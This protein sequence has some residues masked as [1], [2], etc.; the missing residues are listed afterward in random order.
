MSSCGFG[1]MRTS[2]A[3]N[4]LVAVRLSFVECCAMTDVLSLTPNPF[5][6][7]IY[8][9]K[10]NPVAR[11]VF[12]AVG[13]ALSQWEH[14]ETS[15]ATIFSMLMRPTGGNHIPFRAFGGIFSSG[16]RRELI[17]YGAEAYFTT[18]LYGCDK[19]IVRSG[20]KIHGDLKTFLRLF[21]D[22]SR[23]RDEI[24]HGVVMSDFVTPQNLNP[25]YFLVPAL[26]ASRKTGLP[27]FKPEYR[28]SA[29]EL[30]RYSKLFGLLSNRAD[31]LRRQIV[32]FYQALPETARARHP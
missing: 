21:G 13:L 7:P 28:L 22:A 18:L 6:E 26:Y 23:R 14:A 10:G 17:E 20:T 11:D 30:N 5:K 25:G 1:F 9:P 32:D 31:E 29:K 24:A 27:M 12:L 16:T 4:S 2:A 19:E 15:L 8:A 3:I